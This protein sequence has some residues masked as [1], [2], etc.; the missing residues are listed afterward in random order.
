MPRNL[1]QWRRTACRQFWGHDHRLDLSRH[2]V[3]HL[4]GHCADNS[5]SPY[6]GPLD[7]WVKTFTIVETP[8]VRRSLECIIRHITFTPDGERLVVGY[9]F[10]GIWSVFHWF[11]FYTLL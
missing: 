1:A 10:H 4:L 9:I 5:R 2:Q 6:L 7:A 8:P 3:F 11:M